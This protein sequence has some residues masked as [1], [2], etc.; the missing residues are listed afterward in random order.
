M[1]LHPGPDGS[2]EVV[3]VVG[4]DPLARL[5][6]GEEGSVLADDLTELRGLLVVELQPH[7]GRDRVE[8]AVVWSSHR[9][10]LPSAMVPLLGRDLRVVE[11]DVD[12]PSALDETCEVVEKEAGDDA[13][14]HR[15]ERV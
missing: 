10:R 6:G 5:D 13:R 7:G 4:R 2:H 11:G 12:T 9:S 15:Q 8:V 14:R 1:A 3:W